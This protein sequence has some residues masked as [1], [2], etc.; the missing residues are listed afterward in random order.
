MGKYAKGIVAFLAAAAT[1]AVAAISDNTITPAEWLGIVLAGLGA[2]G[3]V[4]V[5]NRTE[6]TR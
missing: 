1:V 2:V 5:P 4:V 3:V 6:G